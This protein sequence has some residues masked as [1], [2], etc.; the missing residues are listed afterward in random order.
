[1]NLLT[2]LHDLCFYFNIEYLITGSFLFTVAY[3][4]FAAWRTG[5]K[6][7]FAT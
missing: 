1:M 2:T 3:F 6:Q 5:L 7:V 4:V